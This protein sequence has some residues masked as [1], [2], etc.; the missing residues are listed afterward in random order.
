MTQDEKIAM[1]RTL[2]VD[3]ADATDA[4]VTVYLSIACFKKIVLTKTS[5]Q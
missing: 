3:D 4:V 1:V 5:T 2:V